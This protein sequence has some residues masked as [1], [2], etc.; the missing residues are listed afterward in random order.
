MTTVPTEF[1]EESQSLVAP[2]GADGGA[3]EQPSQVKCSAG[4]R[5]CLKLTTTPS[6]QVVCLNYSVVILATKFLTQH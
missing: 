2:V 1:E 6:N 4:L 3:A 5:T